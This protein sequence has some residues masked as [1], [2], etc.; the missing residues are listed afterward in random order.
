MSTADHLH[1][2]RDLK[3]FPLVQY[4]E[5]RSARLNGRQLSVMPL[6]GDVFKVHDD[7]SG[8]PLDNALDA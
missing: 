8:C 5:H 3:P 7:C 1:A 4:I 6:T 2:G